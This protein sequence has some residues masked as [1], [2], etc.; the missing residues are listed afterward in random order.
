[1]IPPSF[2]RRFSHVGVWR[3]CVHPFVAGPLRLSLQLEGQWESRCHWLYRVLVFVT[4]GL[5]GGCNSAGQTDFERLARVM[6]R[7]F[8]TEVSARSYPCTQ[9]SAGL[10]HL[11]LCLPRRRSLREIPRL[12]STS[13]RTSKVSRLVPTSSSGTRALSLYLFLHLSLFLSVNLSLFLSLSCLHGS[14]LSLNILRENI[15]L[16]GRKSIAI[17]NGF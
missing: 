5:F 2:T 11:G 13:N 16:R 7:I 15:M 14:H 9:S 6:A 10:S 1:M 8:H 12:S 3:F 4:C 17:L